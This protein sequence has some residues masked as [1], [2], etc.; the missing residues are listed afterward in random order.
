MAVVAHAAPSVV[1]ALVTVLRAASGFKA[2]T[3]SGGDV[4]VFSGTVVGGG[5]MASAVIIGGDGAPGEDIQRPVEWASDWHDLN[6]T[7]LEQGQ[8]QCAAVVW[9]GDANVDVYA[10][11]LTAAFAV[12]NAVDTAIRGVPAATALGVAQVQWCR[13]SGGQVIQHPFNKGTRTA[14][15]FTIDYEAVLTA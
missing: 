3:E 13:T 11:Q 1:N 9:S 6:R 7:L 4:P 12:L 2:P 8:V 14:L 15:Q 5:S 10:D